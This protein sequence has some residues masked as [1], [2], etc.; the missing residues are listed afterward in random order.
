MFTGIR[1]LRGVVSLAAVV[2][3]VSLASDVPAQAPTYLL[4]LSP[5]D[6]SLNIDTASHSARPL[7][8]AYTWP[9]NRVANA[10]LLK[11]DLS[12]L[13]AGATV[14][15]AVVKLALVETDATADTTYTMMA[16]KLVGKNPVIAAAT[17][18]TTDGA[19]PWTPSGCCY[20]GVPLAQSDIS[21][22]YA[23]LAVDKTP[24]F[25]TWPITSMVREWLATPT[26]NFGLVLNSD[27]TVARDRYRYFASTKHA[28]PT[29][30]PVMEITY[31]LP[32]D[33]TPPVISAVASSSI[34]RS[35]ATIS[36]STDEGSDSQIEYGLTTAYGSSTAANAAPVTA[37]SQLLGGL[38]EARVYHYRV[39]SRDAAGNL[40]V[41]GDGTF[42]TLD[43]T[44]PAVSITAP[45]AAATVRGIVTFSAQAS[46]NV[47][48]A[49]VQ[50]RVDGVNLGV[51]DTTAPYAVS[52]N[53]ATATNASHA[54]TAV[55]RD[56]AGNSATSVSVAVTV[57]NDTVAPA[58]SVTAPTGGATVSNTIAV[59]A[60]ASDNVGVAGVQF[61]LDGVDL[62]AE[63]TAS[64]YS[65][66]WNT[67]TA[68]NGSH[69]LTAVARD[70]AGNRTTSAAVTVIVSNGAPPP[71]GS[72]LAALYPG[73]AGIE[74]HPDVIFVERFDEPTLADLFSR[75]TD[76]LNGGTMSYASDVPAGSPV[77][78]SLNIPWVGG[79]TS[80]GGHLYKVLSPGIDDTLYL[81]YY[82]KYPTTGQYMHHGIWAGGYNPPLNYPSPRAGSK[83]AGNDLF[84]A[85]AEQ[86]DVTLR[87]DHYNYWMDMHLSNDGNYWGN[88]L[89]N[90]PNVFGRAGTWMCVE[91]MVKLNTPVTSSNGEHAIW[92]D[93]VKVSHVGQGFPN[94]SW[95]GGI[96]TQNPSGA[97]FGGL[98]WRSD[99]N[100]KINYIW[101]QTYAPNDPAGFSGN[102]KFAHVVA[103]RRYIGCLAP[104]SP[105]PDT[106][107]PSV[108]MTAPAGGATVTG[109]TNVSANASDNV[110]VAGVQFKLDGVN[111]AAEALSSPYA[112][113]W[114][115]SAASAGT[116]TLTAVARDAAGNTRTS[117]SVSVTVAASP[118]PSGSAWPNEPAGLVA[119]TNQPW[120]ALI[121]GGWNRRSGGTDQIVSDPTAPLSP[122]NIL[123]YIYPVG[124]VDGFAPATQYYPVNG[125][126]IFVGM[127]WKPSNPWQ[128]NNSFVNKIQFFQVQNSSVYMTMYGSNGGPLA[129]RV[130]AQW[131]E[132]G[133]QW[134]TP[135]VSSG[136]VA[137]G[138]WHRLEWYLKYDTS[139]GAGNG[140]IR[141]WLD[142][143]LVGN[144]T[145][146]RFPNDGGFVEYQI[147]PT[148]GGN[149][150][151][152]KTQR[153]YYRFDHSYI[154]KR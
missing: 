110:G 117:A 83:P 2:A 52:W 71:P 40:A 148:W 55:A 91:Q 30:W 77:S 129:L 105:T 106:T 44:V 90:D 23:V 12:T 102:M 29:L 47:G 122:S 118:P 80:S 89:L 37:H 7:L 42:K 96:F 45:A 76:I 81:R 99:A 113:V 147:S 4:Q 101:L 19:M 6:T 151:Q 130:N 62:G 97:P 3:V 21:A 114:N 64:P 34:T 107:P 127:W 5:E 53:T 85:A 31:S 18:Y 10:I 150:G 146:V 95:S 121:G 131:P 94:G 67:T 50:F 16:H 98:R 43:K 46:D 86:D 48:V 51:T 13:P 54:L 133:S 136:V 69:T 153:D 28:D 119:M 125:K 152:A 25:K 84:S 59:A 17:G 14:E 112:V 63:D 108:S 109:S 128:G 134:L 1:S 26:S 68:S 87:M 22:P 58:V 123:E 11:F 142:G 126:E 20:N 56:A 8:T 82:I 27:A 73:D 92:V 93:G 79:G 38:L 41:S 116:H 137:L 120:N 70:A 111:L 65:V 115:A 24:G 154:S 36:W 132:M 35:G 74:N 104:S 33:T 103:A 32:G 100:L 144:Y 124:F 49:S 78:R 61:K 88:L 139:Y 145:N 140:I 66:S 149:T 39:R 9:D 75:W 57:A 143:A 15:Q 60:G 138:Q 135:N 141:W 72:G